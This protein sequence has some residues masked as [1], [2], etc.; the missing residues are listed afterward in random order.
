MRTLLT[1]L[2]VSPAFIM[3]FKYPIL[4]I[5][6]LAFL[7]HA[8]A[9]PNGECPTESSSPVYLSDLDDCSVYYECHNGTPLKSHCTSS[10]VYNEAIN[11]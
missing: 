1:I 6:L 7:R 4:L 2:R 10:Y 5:A 11:S 3:I 8:A 9:E